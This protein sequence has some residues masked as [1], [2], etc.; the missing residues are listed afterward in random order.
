MK[1]LIASLLI[2]SA[3]FASCSDDETASTP[4]TGKT[5]TINASSHTNWVYYSFEQDTVVTLSDSANSLDWD[6]AFKRSWIITN[7][8][9]SGKGQA[10]AFDT[11]TQGTSGFDA[12]TSV[13]DTAVFAQDDSVTVAGMGGY[14]TSIVN[15]VLKD[16][17]TLSFGAKTTLI[18]TNNIYIL[19]TAKGK[20]VKLWFVSYY[21]TDGTSAYYTITYKY[22][23]D[24]SKSL[25]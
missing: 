12:L 8:G 25:E 16:C 4:L 7:G 11:K 2:I 1:K 13:P 6:I 14:T 18:P 5:V 22:Q 23:S 24:G 15:P 3:V 21:H 9:L 10:G 17:F 20:Y 19:K